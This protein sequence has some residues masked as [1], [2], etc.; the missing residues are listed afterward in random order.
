MDKFLKNRCLSMFCVAVVVMEESKWYVIQTYSGHEDKIA[1]SIMTVVKNHN[2]EA[3]ITEIK[4]PKEEVEEIKN[5]KKRRVLKKIF[6]G[7]VF[8]K[9]VLNDDTWRAVIGIKGCVGFAGSRRPLPLTKQEAE[10]FG[11]EEPVRIEVPY[12]LGDT[13]Q[14][15]EGPLGGISGIVKEIDIQ[16][17]FVNVEISMFGRDTTVELQ[18]EDIMPIA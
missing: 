18:L 8:V 14:I 17:Q 1:S 9:M 15:I 16:K 5:G 13:V 7:Y 12:K 6:L 10:Q 3:L 11:V 2:L 4:V